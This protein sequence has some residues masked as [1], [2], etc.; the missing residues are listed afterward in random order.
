M[1]HSDGSTE[2]K[3]VGEV[4]ELASKIDNLNLDEDKIFWNFE[5]KKPPKSVCSES[6]PPGTRMAR[7]KGEPVCCFDCIRCSEGEVSNKK[8][9]F[10]CTS[11]RQFNL[12]GMHKFGDVIIGGIFNMNFYT[13]SSDLYFTSE[14]KDPICY[15]ISSS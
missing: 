8:G 4:N 12:N 1:W 7:K 13:K 5:P 14:P 9:P 2:V 10:S 3:N 11:Q 15:G 6:C